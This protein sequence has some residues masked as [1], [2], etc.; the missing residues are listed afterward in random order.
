MDSG[1]IFLMGFG[2]GLFTAFSNGFVSGLLSLV[3]TFIVLT[4]CLYGLTALFGGTGLWSAW[5]VSELIC[6]VITLIVL[7]RY[8]NKYQ[9]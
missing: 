1:E 5:P 6:A 3:R 4:V 2:S 9:Y 7:R 8:R